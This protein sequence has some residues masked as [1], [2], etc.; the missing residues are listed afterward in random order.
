MQGAFQAFVEWYA[1]YGYPALFLGVL[2]ENAGVP[3]PG[4]TAV[5][6]ASFLASPAGGGRF[7]L[8]GVIAVACAAAIV[9]DNVGY[10][11]GRRLA[12]PWLQRGRGF[13]FLTPQGLQKAEGYFARYGAWTVFVAR[14]VTGLRVLAAPAAGVAGMHWPRFFAANAA[15]ALAWASAV[16]LLGYF[17]GRSWEALHHGLSWGAWIILGALLLV[18]GLRYLWRRTWKRPQPPAALAQ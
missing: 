15:G 10:W 7:H 11:L 8:G 1:A 5:L 13:L 9:G 3:V 12:R 4:E 17:F 18:L 16:S 2:L 6:V 14:F